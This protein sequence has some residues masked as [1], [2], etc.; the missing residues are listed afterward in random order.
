LQANNLNINIY[1]DK[2]KIRLANLSNRYNLVHP[3]DTPMLVDRIQV[4]ISH[5]FIKS[6][7]EYMSKMVTK[8][9][10]LVCKLAVGKKF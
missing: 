3:S 7:T 4:K 5:D 6:Q 10:Q 2:T 1:K 8:Q 9:R